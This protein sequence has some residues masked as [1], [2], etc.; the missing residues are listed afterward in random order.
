M[1]D[2]DGMDWYDLCRDGTLVRNE[3][4]SKEYQNSDVIYSLESKERSMKYDLGTI[5]NVTHN[6]KMSYAVNFG[7]E[8]THKT[9]TGHRFTINGDANVANEIFEFCASNSPFVE[10]S[11]IQSADGISYLT[12]SH[13][14]K[15]DDYGTA[16]GLFLASKGNFLSHTHNHPGKSSFF[17]DGDINFYNSVTKYVQDATGSDIVPTF[18]LFIF[19]DK[20]IGGKYYDYKVD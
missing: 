9:A 10:Y 14:R 17:S 5:V 3:E 2:P 15:I 12:T 1:V 4:K 7:D 18:R 8:I 19:I 6:D 13:D 16:L 20:K 11:I